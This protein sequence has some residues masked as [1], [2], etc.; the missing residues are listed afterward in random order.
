[1]SHTS[2]LLLDKG[3]FFGNF[4]KYSKDHYF[5][6]NVFQILPICDLLKLQKKFNNWSQ[7]LIFKK[8]MLML[9]SCRVELYKNRFL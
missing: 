8:N 7:K 5:T 9:E 4:E 1:M 6:I 2:P 3:T